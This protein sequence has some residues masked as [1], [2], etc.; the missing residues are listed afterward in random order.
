MQLSNSY[1]ELPDRFYSR[2]RPTA[3]P[4]PTLLAWNRPLAEELGLADAHRSEEEL[5]EI[6]SGNAVPDGAD[7]IALA[8]AGHQFGYFVPQ[9]GDGRAVL[10]G[11]A[12]SRRDGRRYDIQLKGSGQ[13]P[14]SRNGDGKAPLGPVLREYI[15]SEAMHRL[16]VPTT[17]AL[18]AVATG[19]PVYRETVLPGAVFTRV[20]ASH[21]RIGTFEYFA[22]RGDAEAVERLVDYA[23]QR[24]Y[25]EAADTPNPRLA[26]Y[27]CVVEA[28]ASLVA[29]WLSIGF[30]HGVMN[31]D[32]TSISGETIDYGPC[33]FMDEFD[34]NRVFSSIDRHGRYAYGQQ[35]PIAFWNLARLAEC[36]LPRNDDGKTREA[37]EAELNR[38]PDRFTHHHRERMYAKLGL[39]T[40]DAENAD[41]LN[42]WLRHLQEHAL[43]FTLSFRRLGAR[44]E[45]DD[46]PEFGEFETR[47]KA[48]L[49]RQPES[50][51]EIRER[52]ER[53]N[54][55]YIPRNHQV[56]RV[57]RAAIAGDLSLF[58]ELNRVLQNPYAEQPGFENYAEPPTPEERV[59]QTFCGT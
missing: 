54:P 6:F 3:V 59:T 24:H 33:A 45:A 14:Y 19:S 28:Q 35:A 1:T 38:F 50:P 21:L 43:D 37:L 17:R 23:I 32:N 9:L 55:L 22:T 39:T 16:G 18:A 36:L 8:Y 44:L 25:P 2:I 56:E 5:A 51:A 26:F 4:S 42:A 53:L 48:C 34:I 49:A 15:L 7:P 52:M 58:H 30:I 57:I 47:W 41:L 20:A 27:R 29:Q 11:E 40:D 31:T 13:T 12:T 46:A 10:L